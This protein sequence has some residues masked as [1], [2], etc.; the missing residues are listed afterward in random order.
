MRIHYVLCVGAALLLPQLVLA[1]LPFSTES[2][3]KV[4]AM[5]DSC[6]Q[7]SAATASKYE[8]RKK[9]QVAKLHE[10]ELA[11]AR[12]TQEYKDAYRE[13]T[14]EIEKQPKEKLVAACSAFLEEGK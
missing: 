6:S 11:E 13:T 2:L 5:L 10:K 14:A 3:G 8:Q 9:A 1:G 4:E 12:A 7:A